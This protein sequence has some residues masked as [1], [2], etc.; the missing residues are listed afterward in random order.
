MT[1]SLDLIWGPTTTGKTSYSIALAERT[2]APVISLDRIQCC[3]EVAMGSGRPS[4]DELRGTCRVYLTS[5]K[6]SLGIVSAKEAHMLLKQHVA[7]YAPRSQRIILEGGSVSLINE[8]ISDPYWASYRWTFTRF[9]MGSPDVYI[10]KA[11]QRVREMLHPQDDRL[12]LLA[13]LVHLWRD[14]ALHAAL[15]DI[16]GYR[17]AIQFARTRGLQVAQLS[18]MSTAFEQDLIN[19]IAEEYF[20]HAQWQ[21]R[22]FLSIPSSWGASV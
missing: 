13:E 17:C 5:R 10:A 21:T 8:I 1:S 9:E 6:L 22:E 15:Q 14:P 12:S 19:E 16:D 20:Q 3:P 18:D 7:Q 11:R 2:E 4:T